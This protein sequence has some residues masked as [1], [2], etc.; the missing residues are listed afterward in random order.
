MEE[1]KITTVKER[2]LYLVE[3]KGFAVS[4]FFEESGIGYNNFKGKKLQ[5]SPR[6][7][8][9]EKL[10]TSIPEANLRW[11][12]L[13]EGSMF[14]KDNNADKVNIDSPDPKIISELMSRIDAKDKEIGELREEIGA[15]RERLR[16]NI[17]TPA[18]YTPPAKCADAG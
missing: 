17:N 4:T 2:I 3:S 8:I 16:S 7:D 9:L 14:L 10:I 1:K 18:D 15:L 12:I 13:G 5:S 11:I 6:A